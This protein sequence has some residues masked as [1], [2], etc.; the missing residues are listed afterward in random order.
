[1]YVQVSGME[2]DTII[3]G[4]GA[5]GSVVAQKCA[6]DRETF[7]HITLASRR[8]VS[9]E[10]VAALCQTPIEIAQVDGS[11]PDRIVLEANVE[12]QPTG[13]LQLSAGFSSIESFILSASIRQRNFRGRGQTVG[14]SVNYSR[15]S[16][17]FNLSFSEPYVFD[18]NISAGV[19]LYRRDFNSFNFTGNDRNTT[20]KQSTTGGSVRLGVPLSEYMS[21][22]G[23]Y[24]FNYDDVSL[25][26]NQFF[27]DLDGDDDLCCRRYFFADFKPSFYLVF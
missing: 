25:D 23:S 24:T 14:A 22:V 15:F 5:A 19:D 20:F 27:A 2:F 8:L 4:A 13:E 7:K 17:S 10:N 3:I 6:M 1:M 11:A 16:R 21:L 18:R 26:E 12:E 9:C